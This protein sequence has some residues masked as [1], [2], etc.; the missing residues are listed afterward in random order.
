MEPKKLG[1]G[2]VTA[3]CSPASIAASSTDT[4]DETVYNF[5]V[6]GDHV[7]GV[8]EGCVLIDYDLAI[9]EFAIKWS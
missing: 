1:D 2:R 5:G 4:P 9:Q 6:P 3:S 8:C 7:L